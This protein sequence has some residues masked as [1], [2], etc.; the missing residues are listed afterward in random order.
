MSTDAT[1]GG[2]HAERKIW[3]TQPMRVRVL[4]SSPPDRFEEGPALMARFSH[5]SWLPRGLIAAI[6]EEW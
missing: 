3:A 6:E 4:R 5:T 2:Q 1:P